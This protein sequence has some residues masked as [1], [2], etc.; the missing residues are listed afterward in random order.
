MKSAPNLRYQPK[1]KYTEAIIF[2]GT[3]AWTHAKAWQ[4]ANPIGDTVPPVILGPAQLAALDTLRIIDK[5]RRSAR[6]C[7]A[8]TLDERHLSA[9][10]SRLALAGVQEA[11]MY[12]ESHELLENW[13]PQLAR[14]KQ[15]AQ[16]GESVDTLIQQAGGKPAFIDELAP[17]VEARADGLYYVTPKIDKQSGEVMRPGQ[18]L[19][20]PL[21][22]AG[23]GADDTERFLV[24]RWRPTGADSL[25]TE[26]IPARDIGERDGWARL[27]AGGLSVTAKGHLRAVLA[28]HLLR[29][30]KGDIWRIT[31]LT[32]WQHGA[33]IMPDGEIIGEPHTR[34][35]FNGRS[36]AAGGY[37]VRGTAESWRD[38]V[39]A[40]VA[41]NP[42]MMLGVAA[43]LAAPLVGLVGADGFGL[44]FFQQ[45]SAGKTTTANIATSLYGEPD[46][47]RLTWYGTA[48]GI[49]NEAQAHN[50]ALMPL[51][52]V[53]QGS[54]ARA[55]ATSAYTLFNGVGKLQGAKEGGNRELKRWRTVAI[56][57][58][59][60]DIETFLISGGL[61]PKA[62]QLVRLLNIPLERATVFHGLASGQAHADALRHAWNGNHGAAGRKWIAWLARHPQAARDAVT[63]A[64]ARWRALI[65][66]D[67]GEQVHRVADRF[68]IMEAALLLGQEITGWSEQASRDAIQHGFNAWVRE[69]GTGNKEHRQII[70]QAEAFLN[71]HGFSR[72]A[73]LPWSPQDL[74]V[75]DLAGY[76]DRGSRES[77]PLI[78]YTFPATFENEIAAGFNP[79]QFARVL[80]EAR[81]LEPGQDRFKKKAI[82]VD[83]RQPVFYVLMYQP[84]EGE[85]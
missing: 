2:A 65:P 17:C 10:A 39:A 51:D 47:L 67:Y 13:T 26:A 79:K 72:Y 36:A 69:F 81:M 14:L 82:R 31:A 40:L 54:D 4:E 83:G 41:G 44:H 8:G 77:G 84:E 35:L 24:L 74:P 22:V 75:R 42:S 55:V 25:H 18:W 78:F 57:T 37:T 29:S 56:S 34:V 70:E 59:E 62:G 49:A 12:S 64:A 27:R 21:D 73:P 68:A 3:D 28:D 53:G 63:A 43:A 20:D 11:R 52:E 71:A 7:R 45:S 80:A 33:Y 16:R 23:V 76:R 9:I 46:A 1:D 6:V 38:N 60:M 19:C 30:A 32:G 15:E 58:G 66:A 61:K 48:L 50:D 85:E 5:G